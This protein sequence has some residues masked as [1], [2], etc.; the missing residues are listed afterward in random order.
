VFVEGTRV[1]HLRLEDG[2]TFRL[3]E[4]GPFLRFWSGQESGRRSGGETICF[5]SS[6]TPLLVLDEQLRDREVTE[7]AEGDYFQA[8]QRKVASLRSRPAARQQNS[9]E[10]RD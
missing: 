8:L 9:A 10:K 2:L 4:R 1:D 6:H 5:D 3:A 7:I